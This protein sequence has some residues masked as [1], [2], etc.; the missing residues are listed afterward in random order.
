MTLAGPGL[1]TRDLGQ[2]GLGSRIP[3]KDGVFAT[4][5]VVDDELH[6]HGGIAGP[7]R[8]RRPLAV[9][10]HVADVT[11]WVMIGNPAR[12]TRGLLENTR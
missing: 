8:V 10:A 9:A 6:R 1:R 11:R 12:L 7:V 4:L 3:V 2:E 5:L